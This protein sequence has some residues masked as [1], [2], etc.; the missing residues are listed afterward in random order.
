MCDY[1]SSCVCNID[2]TAL[3]GDVKAF[4]FLALILTAIADHHIDTRTFLVDDE[5]V[6]FELKPNQHVLQLQAV[7]SRFEYVLWAFLIVRLTFFLR[8]CV[9]PHERID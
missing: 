7:D 3:N 8:G 9:S 2:G 5:K 1:S 6:M 4:A